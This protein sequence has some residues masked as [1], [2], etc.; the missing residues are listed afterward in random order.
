VAKK[1]QLLKAFLYNFLSNVSPVHN[2]AVIS[3]GKIIREECGLFFRSY[4]KT[5]GLTIGEITL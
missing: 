1:N 5:V 2:C 3:D 4:P